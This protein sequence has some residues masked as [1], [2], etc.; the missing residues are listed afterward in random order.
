M[1]EIRPVHSFLISGMK[2]ISGHFATVTA[3]VILFLIPAEG[4]VFLGWD[5]VRADDSGAVAFGFKL[6]VGVCLF[7][8]FSLST[9]ITDSAL[10]RECLDIPALITRSVKRPFSGLL[11]AFIF[12]GL[13]RP[14]TEGF[15]HICVSPHAVSLSWLVTAF[16]GWIVLNVMTWMIFHRFSFF[17]ALDSP[18]DR[19]RY[20]RRLTEG[21]AW[22]ILF[23]TPVL[24]CPSIVIHV[25]RDAIVPGAGFDTDLWVRML[26]MMA[27][28]YAI[29]FAIAGYYALFRELESGKSMPESIDPRQFVPAL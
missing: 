12:G 3:I 16:G 7:L 5:V 22:L 14:M 21:S 6:V 9:I 13:L 18:S 20:V 15:I 4:M 10:R 19:D 29:V 23:S 11:L 17:R 24:W 2:V 27:N 26:F 8:A 1:S 25:M 28:G